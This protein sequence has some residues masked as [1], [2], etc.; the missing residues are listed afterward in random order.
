VRRNPFFSEFLVKSL[1]DLSKPHGKASSEC[2][3]P[4]F[5]LGIPSQ[6]SLWFVKTARKNKS[7]SLCESRPRSRIP[8]LFRKPNHCVFPLWI[9]NSDPDSQPFS[10]TKSLRVFFVN[11][12]FWVGFTTFSKMNT[13]FTKKQFQNTNH[14]DFWLGILKPRTP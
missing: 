6:K 9:Q 1:C 4:L 8:G 3:G 13:L 11:P 12:S 5:F 14:K 2:G 10:K 7:V